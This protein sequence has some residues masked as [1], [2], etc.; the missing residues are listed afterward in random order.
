MHFF[1]L[2]K[3]LTTTNCSW[4][5]KFYLPTEPNKVNPHFQNHQ[6]IVIFTQY[7]PFLLLI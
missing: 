7:L 1:F 6:V 2:I 4:G 3:F 5:K